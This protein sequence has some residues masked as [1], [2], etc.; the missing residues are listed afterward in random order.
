MDLKKQLIEDYRE[1]KKQN[2]QL[3]ERIQEA[4]RTLNSCINHYDDPNKN[5][6][7]KKA[8]NILRNKN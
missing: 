4:I 3:E 5:W 2:N 7:I 6:G 1:L 8:I